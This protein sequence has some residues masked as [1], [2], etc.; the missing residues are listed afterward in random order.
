MHTVTRLL[1]QPGFWLLILEAVGKP[2]PARY[3]ADRK[4]ICDRRDHT[5]GVCP[6]AKV[7]NAIYFYEKNS[8]MI[9]AIEHAKEAGA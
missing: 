6:F 7:I 4:K 2:Y 1:V 3:F 9:Y 5:R 8:P